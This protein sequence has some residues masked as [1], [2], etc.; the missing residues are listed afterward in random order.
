MK[1][2]Y[3]DEQE[4][5]AKTARNFVDANSPV[6]RIRELRDRNDPTGFS[7]ALW[8]QMSELGWTGLRV[9]EEYDGLGLGLFDLCPVLEAAGRRLMPEPFLSTVLLGTH[10]LMFGGTDAQKRTWLPDI[11]AGEKLV[12]LAYQE[13]GS[14]YELDRVA[15]TATR[16]S[17][18]RGYELS[19]TKVQ[20][21]DGHVADLLIVSARTEDGVSL[22]LVDPQTRGITVER[23]IRLD[24]RNAALV[25]LEKVNVSETDVLGTPGA[26]VALLEQAVDVATVGLS[27]EMLGAASQALD[28]TLAYLNERVQFG[29]TI[30]SFQALQHRASRLFIDLSLARSA[31]LAAARTIDDEPENAPLMA[32]LAKAKCSDTFSAVAKEAVQMHGGIGVTDEHH[33]GFYLKRARA[34]AATFGDSAW[35]RAR[36]ATLSGY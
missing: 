21:L 34:A 32:S 5:L 2:I 17:M 31:V 10:A 23:Q 15:T 36:W 26:G 29:V 12:A 22:F 16:T 4:L 28:D 18:D 27:A 25:Q 33:I 19:G 14:R 35:L 30:G 11:A 24:G 3:N 20:V 13:T 6:S 9:P 8:A 7:R 1:L